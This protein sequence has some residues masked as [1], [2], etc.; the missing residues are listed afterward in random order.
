MMESSRGRRELACLSRV[1]FV[2]RVRIVGL[3]AYRGF[4]CSRM[5][6]EERSSFAQRVG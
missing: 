6:G 5:E 4:A 3:P 2:A 1:R